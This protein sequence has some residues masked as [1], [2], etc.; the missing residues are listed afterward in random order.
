V[1]DL[2][3]QGWNY[4]RIPWAAGIY[5]FR[6]HE[7]HSGIGGEVVYIGRGGSHAG[8]DSTSICSRVG[9]FIAAAMGFWAYHSGGETFF[10]RSAQGGQQEPVHNLSVRDLEVSWAKDDDPIC[11]EAEEVALLP[12]MPLFNRQRTRSC[13]REECSRANCLSETYKV[14]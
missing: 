10:R 4:P 1:A 5:R 3:D 13:R 6:V 12:S 11:R 14:W 2:L 8:K 7:D 9:S